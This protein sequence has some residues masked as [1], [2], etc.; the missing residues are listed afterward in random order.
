MRE[1]LTN[2]V[3]SVEG[4]KRENSRNKIYTLV[5]VSSDIALG[6]KSFQSIFRA[7]LIDLIVIYITEFCLRFLH[8][9]AKQEGSN[10]LNY[11]R[12]HGTFTVS[13]YEPAIMEA[14]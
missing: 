12:L 10:S 3:Y 5:R 11:P 4:I 13:L 6:C 9:M 8:L 14:E 7:I 1:I 2:G